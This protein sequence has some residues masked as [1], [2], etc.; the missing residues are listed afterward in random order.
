L[1]SSIQEGETNYVI[2]AA[3]E[4]LV[5]S[6]TINFTLG[7]TASGSDYQISSTNT[8]VTGTTNQLTIPAD[9]WTPP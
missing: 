3:G 4:Q 5:W 1:R 9:I 6:A 2:S 8:L 7:G